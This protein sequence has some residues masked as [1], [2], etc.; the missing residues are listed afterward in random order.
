ML[1][2]KRV[3]AVETKYSSSE[4]DDNATPPFVSYKSSRTVNES[5]N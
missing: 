2:T 5:D 4:D 3:K 1:Q